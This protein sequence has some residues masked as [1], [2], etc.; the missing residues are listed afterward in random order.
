M[1]A[2]AFVEVDVGGRC[3]NHWVRSVSHGRKG[4][5]AAWPAERLTTPD[6]D[7]YSLQSGFA[8]IL[9]AVVVD[10]VKNLA[11]NLAA[12]W[13]PR[14]GNLEVVAESEQDR[15]LIPP[16]TADAT[17]AAMRVGRFDS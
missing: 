17:I 7:L 1:I 9:A 5:F 6:S 14:N 3:D 2:A 15:A 10:V 8:D 16:V 12:A 13:Q 4:K 11:G